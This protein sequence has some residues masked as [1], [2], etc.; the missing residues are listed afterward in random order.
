MSVLALFAFSEASTALRRRAMQWSCDVLLP[1]VPVDVPSGK[2]ALLRDAGIYH[3]AADMMQ[4]EKLA[5]AY[6]SHW[7][8]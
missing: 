7:L 4:R 5:I 1:E 8:L 3:E 2:P 6:R